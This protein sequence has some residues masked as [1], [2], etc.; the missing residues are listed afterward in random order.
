MNSRIP[1]IITQPCSLKQPAH[2]SISIIELWNRQ[3][4][5]NTHLEL[6]ELVHLLVAQL[7]HVHGRRF[8][9]V[10][11][12]EHQ[13]R[14]KWGWTRHD[15]QGHVWKNKHKWGLVWGEIGGHSAAPEVIWTE[16]EASRV[17]EMT[18]DGWAEQTRAPPRVSHAGAARLE[19][20]LGCP[21]Y[22]WIE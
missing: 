18:M 1:T 16:S 15:K 5:I 19:H 11:P 8:W 3:I 22:W 12:L 14:A 13:D 21:R 7:I 10:A 2:L 4:P 9:N 6:P 17:R 20:P